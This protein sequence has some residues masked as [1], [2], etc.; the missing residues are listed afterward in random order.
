M[1]EVIID[2]VRYV[3]EQPTAK[4]VPTDVLR[5]INTYGGGVH[6]RIDEN[7]ELLE[8]L[9]AHAPEF[10]REHDWVVGWLMAQDDFLVGLAPYAKRPSRTSG[11]YPRPWPSVKI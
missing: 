1:S 2:G 10:L 6:K 3:P 5:I 7:R 4:P 11:P 9:V 8:E